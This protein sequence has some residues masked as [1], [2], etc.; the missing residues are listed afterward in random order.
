MMP[1]IFDR[2]DDALIDRVFQPLV[3]WIAASMSLDCFAQA[4]V[5]T[6]VSAIA[7]ILSQA[8]DLAVAAQSGPVGRQVLQGVLLLLGLGAIMVLHTLFQRAGGRGGQGRLNP[9]RVAMYAHR[10]TILLGLGVSVLKIALGVGSFVLLAMALFATAAVYAGACS[11]SP[12]RQQARQDA[13]GGWRAG[14]LL[15]RVSVRPG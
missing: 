9:L 13:S 8:K 3:D 14:A 1:G 10:M 11:N 6:S 12:P 7:W 15:Q 2:V 5:C 4:R